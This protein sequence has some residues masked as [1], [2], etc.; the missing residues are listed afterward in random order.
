[1][2]GRAVAEYHHSVDDEDRGGVVLRLRIDDA[3]GAWLPWAQ[4]IPGGVD[5][6]VAGDEEARAICAVLR[7]LL[8][9]RSGA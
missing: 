7:G 1:M 3:G 5:I 9:R 8:E 2:S 4:N 6:H